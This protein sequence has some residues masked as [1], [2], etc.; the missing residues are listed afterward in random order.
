MGNIVTNTNVDREKKWNYI[1]NHFHKC[2]VIETATASASIYTPPTGYRFVLTDIIMSSENDN[3]I[4]LNEDV[5]GTC[6][7]IAVFIVDTQSNTSS[8][9]QH[10]FNTPYYS[11][12]DNND[13][14]ITTTTGADVNYSLTGYLIEI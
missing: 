12:E 6:S 4:T 3:I 13:L 14:L 11:K 8:N 5:G 7:N 10:S 1:N 2:G 9:F